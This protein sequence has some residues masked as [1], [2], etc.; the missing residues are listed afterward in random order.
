MIGDKTL[1]EYYNFGVTF[2]FVDEFNYI[3]INYNKLYELTEDKIV[4]S[5]Y[6]YLIFEEINKKE[7]KYYTKIFLLI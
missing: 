6:F 5:L 1:K 7:I 4:N 2:A 3:K